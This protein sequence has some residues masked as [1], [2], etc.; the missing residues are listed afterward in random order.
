METTSH[1]PPTSSGDGESLASLGERVGARPK[2]SPRPETPGAS[3][4]EGARADVEIRSEQRLLGSDGEALAKAIEAA[5]WKRPL[6]VADRLAK[7]NPGAAAL[8]ALGIGAAIGLVLGL[9]FSRD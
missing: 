8:V 7:R 4:T 9:A 2:T 1:K 6:E 5:P 3:G